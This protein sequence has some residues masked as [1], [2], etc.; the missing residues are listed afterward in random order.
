MK[1]RDFRSDTITKPTDT[2][3]QAMKDALVG[4]DV[5]Q[6]DPTVIELEEYCAKLLNKPAA[7]FF[8]SGTM[9]N[10]VAI[11]AHTRR[12]D[13]VIFHADAHPVTH[14]VGAPCV[15]A[16]VF[17]KTIHNNQT[18][19]QLAD[20]LAAISSD[21][22][23]EPPTT[24]LC[25]E[26]ATGAGTLYT[27]KQLAE[28]YQ[29]AN[30]HKIAVHLDGARLFNAAIALNCDAKNIASYADSVMFCLSKGLCAPIGSILV[31]TKDFILS[32]RRYRKMLG[33]GMRQVGCMAAAGLV[34]IKQMPPQL[35]IDHQN[36]NYLATLLKATPN[37]EI[38]QKI[39]I[40]MVFFRF[41]QEINHNAF[42]HHLQKSNIKI[43]PSN[44]IYR[45]V[46]SHEV[47]KK[48][49]EFLVNTVGTFK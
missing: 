46:T 15:L 12:G 44:D 35:L 24:L 9:A 2:M 49:I 42:F 39:N 16:G 7:L 45:L 23:H 1:V 28:L 31:G 43:N 13:Q 37:I 20:F 3:R 22:I 21:D 29:A 4:D 11:M 17:P 27:L 47:D 41:R 34:A 40:N 38:V 10:Q 19:I 5:Y 36:A 48:D 14:E 8:P 32:A 33:G 18:T 26:N 6:D 25:L 30:K